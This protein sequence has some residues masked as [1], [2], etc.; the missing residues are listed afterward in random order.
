VNYPYRSN[1][2]GRD[3]LLGAPISA[4]DKEKIAH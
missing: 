3:F 1:E 2:E 4:A